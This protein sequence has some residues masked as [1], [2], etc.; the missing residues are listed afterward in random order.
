V[1]SVVCIIDGMVIGALNAAFS[2]FLFVLDEVD[3]A[4]TLVTANGSA[5]AADMV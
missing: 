5:L 3:F 4:G 2:F 1:G